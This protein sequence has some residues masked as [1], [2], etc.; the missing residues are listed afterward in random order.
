MKIFFI[1]MSLI[2]CLYSVQHPNKSKQAL[3]ISPSTDLD[4]SVVYGPTLPC[5]YSNAVS[6]YVRRIFQDSRG[7]LWFGTNTDGV[8]LFDGY[9][10]SYL[11]TDDGL[12][13]SQITGIIE[14]KEGKIWFSTNNG[15][16]RFD[17]SAGAGKEFQNFG[18]QEGLN[19]KSTW[20][21]FQDRKGT[22]WAGTLN[23][24]CRL[25]GYKFESFPIPSAEKS[26]IRSITQD[27]KG[28]LWFATADKGAFKFDG[29]NFKQLS[30]KDGLCS[31]DLTSIVEDRKGTL[32]FGSMDGG[33]SQYNGKTFTNLMEGNGIGNNEVWTIYEDRNGRILFSAEGFGIYSYTYLEGKVIHFGDKQGLHIGAVQSIYHDREGRYWIGGGSGLVLFDG[34]QLFTPVTKNGPWNFG[35]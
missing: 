13:G 9:K 32:W 23:G 31:N 3:S 18:E 12:I 2:A 26:W 27:S 10:L 35:C 16:S 28:N 1:G 29:T 24:L 4:D 34:N 19:N 14:D 11:N 33:L 8:A 7:F 5:Y 25:N 22:I 17:L 21:I 6:E 20:C 15:I 30:K